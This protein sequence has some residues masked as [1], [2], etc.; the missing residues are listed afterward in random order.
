VPSVFR[1]HL[2][3]DLLGF[4]RFLESR[5][6]VETAR[7]MRAHR[8]VV[9]RCV[10]GAPGVDIEESGDS[11]HLVFRTPGKAIRTA[12]AVMAAVDRHNEKHPDL[13]LLIRIGVHAGE[14]I[15][16]GRHYVGSSVGLAGALT[17][18]ARAGQI[19]VSGTVR[20]LL[21][22]ARL[23]GLR[24][25]GTWN[26]PGVAQA[27]HVYELETSVQR[28]PR[29]EMAPD[30]D[31]VLATVLFTDIVRSTEHAVSIGDHN[32]RDL[33]ERHHA[34][35][36]SELERYR[37]DEVDT[38][39]DGF[40]ATFDGPS[41]AIRCA[42]A[43]R[44]GVQALGLEIRAGVHIGE[45]EIVA[46]KLGGIA[47]VTGARIR[48]RAIG[49]E[50]LVSQMVKELGAGGGVRFADRGEY[51][52]KGLLGEWRLYAAELGASDVEPSSSSQP[53]STSAD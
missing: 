34:V 48:D 25:L 39:G 50:V 43:I 42:L 44:D 11:F 21:R 2:I 36:R 8:R 53:L 1:A 18:R 14:S 12:L 41:R 31:R 13:T 33:V 26:L 45:C 49:N 32:W 35:V 6:D 46:G 52:L 28:G 20:E 17:L 15:R 27:V 30:V 19:L 51:S 22:G 23:A 4:G 10:R 47:V 40:F 37:G 24:D 7:L 3:T 29:L 9:G 5:G 38:A 16:Q